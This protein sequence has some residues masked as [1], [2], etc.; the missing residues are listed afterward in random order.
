MPYDKKSGRT[1]TNA[2]ARKEFLAT[3]KP[4]SPKCPCG[5]WATFGGKCPK[6]Y[7]REHPGNR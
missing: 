6:C 3:R 2:E 7:D 4:Y 5:E 1:L